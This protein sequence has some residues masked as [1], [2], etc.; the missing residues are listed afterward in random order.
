MTN[1][2]EKPINDEQ[3]SNCEFFGSFLSDEESNEIIATIKCVKGKKLC[4]CTEC[5]EAW[6]ERNNRMAYEDYRR[7]TN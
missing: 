4:S 3:P 5:T 2:F 1:Y 6:I 7:D